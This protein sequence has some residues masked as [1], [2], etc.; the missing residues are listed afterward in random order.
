MINNNNENNLEIPIFDIFEDKK[1]RIKFIRKTFCL[2]FLS[3]FTTLSICLSFKYVNI[4]K[5]FLLSDQGLFLGPISLVT[6]FTLTFTIICNDYLLRKYFIKYIIYFLFT[7]S[8]SCILGISI[9]YSS[10]NLLISS[11]I[12]TTGNISMLI[13]YSLITTNYFTGYLEYYISFI[14]IILLGAIF[15]IFF[16]NSIFQLVIICFGCFIFSIIVITD[17]QM[18]FGQ[19][20]IKYKFSTDDEVLA[21]LCLYLDI[22]NIF[23]YIFE[24]LILTDSN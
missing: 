19:K 2:F 21:A 11:I 8:L 9:I 17:L 5:N 18:I 20:H 24:I 16:N 14:N 4:I 22:I 13:L 6:L 10:S 1:E 7:L 12:I 23:I 3:I 15:N